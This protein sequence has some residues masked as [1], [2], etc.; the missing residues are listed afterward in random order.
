MFI[1]AFSFTASALESDVSNT[2]GSLNWTLTTD[3]TL[4]I[5]GSGEMLDFV[6][7]NTSDAWRAYKNDITKV[8]I[9]ENVTSVCDY[10]FRNCG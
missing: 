9:G 1:S 2:W 4:T 8:V 6:S 10:A 3:G 5:S 7:K